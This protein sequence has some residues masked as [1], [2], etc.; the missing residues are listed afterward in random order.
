MLL[1]VIPIGSLSS[2]ID[3]ATI[4]VNLVSES[5]VLSAIGMIWDRWVELLEVIVPV[6]EWYRFLLI[7][8]VRSLHQQ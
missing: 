3:I 7:S 4:K 6:I 1:G 8:V 2:E 5:I